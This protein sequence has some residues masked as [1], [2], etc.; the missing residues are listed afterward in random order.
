M[1]VNND[2]QGNYALGFEERGGH[3][4]GGERRGICNVC[5]LPGTKV[6][7]FKK[8]TTS[9]PL[10]QNTK[11]SRLATPTA[12]DGG[13]YPC[14]TYGPQSC[15]TTFQASCLLLVTCA[16]LLCSARA[17]A[18]FQKTAMVYSHLSRLRTRV[19]RSCFVEQRC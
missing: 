6:S 12:K 11:C 18:S 10:A 14:C 2:E 1:G 17:A 7:H 4:F 3:A 13:R 5:L 9:A 19:R 15:T 16:H 8:P